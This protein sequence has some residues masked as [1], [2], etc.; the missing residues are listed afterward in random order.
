[1]Q[2]T[3]TEVEFSDDSM[4]ALVYIGGLDTTLDGRHKNM[5]WW[6][7]HADTS[8]RAQNNLPPYNIPTDSVF[9]MPESIS[10]ENMTTLERLLRYMEAVEDR[11]SAD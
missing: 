5:L 9:R 8:W 11:V 10:N 6:F 1:M 4:R 2:M 3:D 7:T